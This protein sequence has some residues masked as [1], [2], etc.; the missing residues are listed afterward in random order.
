VRASVIVPVYNA[1]PWLDLTL[2]SWLDQADVGD[3]E[4]ILVDNNSVDGALEHLPR[5]PRLCLLNEQAQ[6][7]YRARN[8]G[9]E[10]ATGEV[11]I[12]TDPDCRAEATWLAELLARMGEPGVELVMGRDRH[13]G[14]GRSMRLLSAYDHVKEWWT[15][16]QEDGSL[17][18]GHTNNMAVSRAAWAAAGPFVPLSRGADV[19]LVQRV[20]ERFDTRAVVYH[21]SALVHHLEVDTPT[22]YFRKCRLYGRSYRQYRRVV[23]ARPLAWRDRWSV[24]RET[25]RQERLPLIEASRL[26]ALLL[27]GVA[28]Y[29]WGRRLDPSRLENGGVSR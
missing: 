9:V 26:L 28:C 1:A 27:L 15:L 16:S 22:A 2:P 14:D 17:Y 13:A 20:V 12:F 29:W 7:A 3:Y 21:P 5:H 23:N 24:Y 8:R 6:G 25:V 4:V 19:I 11:L 18:Y 10:A